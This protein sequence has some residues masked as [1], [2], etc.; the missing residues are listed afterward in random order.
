MHCSSSLRWHPVMVVLSELLLILSALTSFDGSPG[1][2]FVLTAPSRPVSRMFIVLGTSRLSWSRR[3]RRTECSRHHTSTMTSHRSFFA[4]ISARSRAI[5]SLLCVGLDPH[6]SELKLPSD[7]D[8]SSACHAAYNFCTTLINATKDQCVCYKPN[9]AFFESLGHE[10]SAT[11]RKV[12]D[13]IHD[14]TEC[15]VLLDVKRGD[16]GS[17]AA[18]YADACYVG[19]EGEGVT[20]SPL[21]GW[22]SVEPFVTGELAMLRRSV[23]IDCICPFI[24]R[25]IRCMMN[26][27]SMIKSIYLLLF[28]EPGS[29]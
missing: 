11:L 4:Q 29:S 27:L 13:Y 8:E 10:G 1:G 25:R 18:A 9:A 24:C 26:V 6:R 21:M 16:I 23:A 20:L 5:N 22:D 12:V 2:W 7:A 17:T 14:N 3:A 15:T 28:I 19:L